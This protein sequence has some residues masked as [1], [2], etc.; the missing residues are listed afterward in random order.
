[1]TNQFWLSLLLVGVVAELERIE[2]RGEEGCNCDIGYSGSC[3]CG[4]SMSDW[5]DDVL[6]DLG[7]DWKM[8]EG[9]EGRRKQKH[10]EA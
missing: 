8:W 10:P 7:R 3:G 4:R 2:E 6:K 5:I 9:R 1:L